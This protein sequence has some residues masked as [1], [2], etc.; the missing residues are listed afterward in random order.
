M[1]KKVL[2]TK[3]LEIYN[4]LIEQINTKRIC[5]GDQLPTEK[6]IMEQFNVNRTT[7]RTALSKFEKADMIMRRSGK[8]TFLIR[9]T[10]PQ[11]A[12]TLNKLEIASQDGVTEN[13]TYTT[14]E[15]KWV[16]LPEDIRMILNGK[17]SK[18]LAFKRIISIDGELALFERTFLNDKLS[19]IFEDLI[20]EINSKRYGKKYSYNLENI[21]NLSRFLFYI[22]SIY[23]PL[24]KNEILNRLNELTS[25][26]KDEQIKLKFIDASIQ[27]LVQKNR[28]EKDI[29][30]DFKEIYTL[31]DEGHEYVYEN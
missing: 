12:R 31:S 24:T 10:P 8:G 19:D 14:I 11:F 16:E 30:S 27:I 6:S 5:V 18:H 22:I 1:S 4:W 9:N 29:T 7:V 20:E 25:E 17:N 2:H 23:Q 28:I 13:T 3:H 21:F 15:K 26:I